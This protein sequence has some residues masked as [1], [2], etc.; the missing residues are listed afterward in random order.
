MQEVYILIAGDSDEFPDG[1][2]EQWVVGVFSSRA[3]ADDAANKDLERWNKEHEEKHRHCGEWGYYIE[4][5]IVDA[6]YS[7]R[8]LD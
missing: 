6:I 2:G 5:Y 4:K 7:D 1:S 8:K 3:K